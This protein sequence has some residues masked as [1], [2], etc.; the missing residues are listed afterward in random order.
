MTGPEAEVSVKGK[1][2]IRAQV[3]ALSREWPAPEQAWLEAFVE[4]IRNDYAQVVRRDGRPGSAG[5]EGAGV[6]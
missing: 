5:H 4:A 2:T 1:T 3:R 6:G